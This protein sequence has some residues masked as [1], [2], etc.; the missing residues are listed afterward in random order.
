MKTVFFSFFLAIICL[1]ANAQNTTIA[2]GCDPTSWTPF[3]TTIGTSQ[4]SVNC[5][6]QFTMKKGQMVKMGSTYKC[7]GGC[8]PKY[9]IY[10]KNAAGAMVWTKALSTMA[11]SYNFKTVGNFTIDV[12]P[13]CLPEK[14][15][16]C[17]F[18][19]KVD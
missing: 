7:K 5:G 16:G 6:N 1:S 12:V 18:Y 8:T 3:L 15:M 2:C 17:R 9:I 10:I 11:F 13:V 19:F 4:S 14:C